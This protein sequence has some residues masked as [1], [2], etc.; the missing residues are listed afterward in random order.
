VEAIM[1][2]NTLTPEIVSVALDVVDTVVAI[3]F[4]L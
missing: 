2:R 3:D 1:L 4:L